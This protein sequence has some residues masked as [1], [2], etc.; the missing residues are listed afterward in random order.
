MT[1]SLLFISSGTGTG[2]SGYNG[3]L[4]DYSGVPYSNL[5]F[6]Q[7]YC[8]ITNYQVSNFSTIFIAITFHR[9][10]LTGFFNLFFRTQQMLEIATL[11]VSMT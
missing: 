10:L 4:Q 7:P 8:T 6:H 11:A 2:G 9:N 3:G 5:D 1:I